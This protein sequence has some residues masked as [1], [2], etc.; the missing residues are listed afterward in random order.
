M[1]TIYCTNKLKELFGASHFKD[2]ASSEN[3]FGGWNGHLFYF[4]GKKCLI[5]VNNKS[6]YAVF[7]ADIKKADLKDFT[8]LFLNRLTEQLVYDKVIDRSETLTTI[9]KFLPASL[10]KT[11]NDRKALGTI[12]EFIFYF[13]FFDTQE[14]GG[15]G[16]LG[17]NNKI[18]N[19]L[20]GA[21]REKKH[22]YGKPVEDMKELLNS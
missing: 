8:T 15:K 17:I 1:T 3:K 20:A 2:V 18:N 10:S 22:D 13:K 5:F 21:G 12:N 11:N 14:W 9:Q 19:S 4:D 7:L 6:Y 16:L